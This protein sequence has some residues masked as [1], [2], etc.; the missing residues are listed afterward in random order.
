M[1]SA[2]PVVRSVRVTRRPP[3]SAPSQAISRPMASNLRPFD[4]PLGER[5]TAV[6]PVM[7][8]WRQMWPACM[9]E[10]PLKVMSLK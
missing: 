8:S 5:K 9:P 2:L 4:M 1:I 7:G 10:T 6:S 3:K